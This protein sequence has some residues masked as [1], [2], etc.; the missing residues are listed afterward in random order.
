MCV[1]VLRGATSFVMGMDSHW[2]AIG[3]VG[4]CWNGWKASCGVRGDD[5]VMEAGWV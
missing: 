2:E 4:A 1:I 5:E 3:R